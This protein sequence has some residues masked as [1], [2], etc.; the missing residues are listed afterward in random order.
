MG[1]LQAE[2]T[3]RSGGVILVVRFAVGAVLNYAFGVALA[4]LIVPDQFGIVASLQNIL[5][6]ATG[7]LTAGF[8]WALA[9]SLSEPAADSGEGPGSNTARQ[10]R[11]AL[12]GN[13]SLGAALAALLVILQLSGVHLLATSSVPVL[14]LVA[15][16]H[17]VLSFN[18]V[19]NGALQGT[20][21][22]GGLGAMQSGEIVVKCAVALSLVLALGAGAAGVAA[23]FL[24]GSIA[25]TA[26]ALRALSGVL[27][28]RGPLR[29]L[30][31]TV[32]AVPFWIAT[33]CFT[34]LLTADI[35]GL[36]VLGRGAVVT[37]GAVGVYQACSILARA[38][39]FVADALVDA[40]FPFI[41][42]H[43]ESPRDS[44]RWLVAAVRWI[45]I[46]VVPGLLGLAIVPGPL[47]DLFFPSRYSHAEAVL[48]L[49]AAG[50]L[51][52]IAC[53]VAVKAL[54]AVGRAP[55]AAAL[56]PW[57]VAV[58]TALLV[59]LVPR[60][61]LTGAATA[62]CVGAW[63]G[64]VG[65]GVAYWRIQRP[66]P[67]PRG[68]AARWLLAVGASAALLAVANVAGPLTWVV[69]VAAIITYVVSCVRL[70]VIE[71]E[72]VGQVRSRVPFLRNSEDRP[73][74]ERAPDRAT[75]PV[76]R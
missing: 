54:F 13:V 65:V 63:V 42:A 6:L 26:V 17:V 58:E 10:F 41:A 72:L 40:A 11:T 34:Y 7:V 69:V 21:R 23:G 43:R 68:P 39:Y 73:A 56:M 62:G 9:T 35:V 27:P 74:A 55:V 64:A 12:V 45:P 36:N 32:T 37:A 14:L 52:I 57:A 4:W 59:V 51:G 47:L 33:V 50:T 75:D 38:G 25:A 15:A 60:W 30:R 29:N 61:G 19:L 18:A 70:Q 8:P 53:D 49:L 16:E 71:P 20:R 67:V 44:H 3:A 48:R 2:R 46:A 22:F 31:S 5:L 76:P 66:E 24:V 1:T 28:G